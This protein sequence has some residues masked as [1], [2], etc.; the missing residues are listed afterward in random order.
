MSAAKI[1]GK[2]AVSG[3]G[4]RYGLPKPRPTTGFCLAVYA[5]S[6]FSIKRY[7][8]E[9]VFLVSVGSGLKTDTIAR[10]GWANHSLECANVVT[11]PIPS[12]TVI[13]IG[14]TNHL[15]ALGL[16]RIMSIQANKIATTRAT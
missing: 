13:N 2:R 11:Y 8:L 9:L 7:K 16:T 1:P 15:P 5:R 14:T 6:L 12:A 10:A 3:I 4:W